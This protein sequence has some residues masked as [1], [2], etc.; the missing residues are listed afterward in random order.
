MSPTPAA[1]DSS[2][3]EKLRLI[4]EEALTGLNIDEVLTLFEAPFWNGLYQCWAVEKQ[5]VKALQPHSRHLI[6]PQLYAYFLEAI[7]LNTQATE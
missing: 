5:H 4:I 6:Q 1:G 7:K 3:K 2:P